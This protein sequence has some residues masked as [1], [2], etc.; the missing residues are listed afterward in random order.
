MNYANKNLSW[1]TISIFSPG[2]RQT[3]EITTLNDYFEFEDP[4]QGKDGEEKATSWHDLIYP[5]PSVKPSSKGPQQ[6]YE[7]L[8]EEVQS[9][10]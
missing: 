10:E 4:S 7:E 9:Q 2:D 1:F 8:R 5:A 3:Y 6:T